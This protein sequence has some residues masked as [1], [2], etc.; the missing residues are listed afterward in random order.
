MESF[1]KKDSWKCKLEYFAVVPPPPHVNIVKWYTDK[2]V[3]IM[4]VI[5]TE[6]M[7]VHAD[8]TIHSKIVLI[9]WLYIGKYENVI[10]LIGRF[11]ALLVY[12]KGCV[13]YIFVSL[14]FKS[15][16]EHLGNKEKCFYFTSKA[17]FVP[18]K[19]KF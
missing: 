3:Y 4:G 15:K 2:I 7:F 17:L 14:V 10:R 1:F 18:E 9:T 6:E 19:I 5:A 8:E 12:L 11:H 16:G 13:R